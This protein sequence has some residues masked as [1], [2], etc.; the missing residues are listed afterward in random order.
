LKK[1][2]FNIGPTWNGKNNTSKENS[3]EFETYGKCTAKLVKCLVIKQL[4]SHFL[5]STSESHVFIHSL[6]RTECVQ[7]NVSHTLP[8]SEP[9]HQI[10]KGL[11][12]ASVL[13]HASGFER[14]HEVAM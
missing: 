8:C 11:C 3:M 1:S 4:Y 2:I 10:P 13:K 7:T 9:E 12:N 6:H 5:K 14:A